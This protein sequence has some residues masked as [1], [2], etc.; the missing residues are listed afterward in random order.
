MRAIPAGTGPSYTPRSARW[1]L[2]TI[3]R[4]ADDAAQAAPTTPAACAGVG[5]GA[6]GHGDDHDRRGRPR[7]RTPDEHVDADVCSDRAQVDLPAVDLGLRR[8]RSAHRTGAGL[9]EQPADVRPGI[10]DEALF[11]RDRAA[12]VR[13]A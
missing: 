3:R 13:D 7:R 6:R 9:P 1:S 5:R 2:P 11:G 10:D 4:S 12:A 8:A